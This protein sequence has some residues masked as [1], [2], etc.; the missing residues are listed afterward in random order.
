[1]LK[2]LKSEEVEFGLAREFLL[3]LRREFREGD[4]KS[5]K[6]AELRRIEQGGR[7]IEEFVQEFWK[8]A[9]GSSYKERI[10]VEEFE[11]R[12]SKVIKKKL[13]EAEKLP[14]SIEQ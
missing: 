5:V 11:K 6:V 14:A 12:M 3:E 1:M 13:I 4:E 2:D 8:V 9:K 7:I 10:L